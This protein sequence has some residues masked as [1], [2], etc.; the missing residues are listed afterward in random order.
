MPV[1]LPFHIDILE[2]DSRSIDF[3]FDPNALVDDA[4]VSLAVA[5]RVDKA[6]GGRQDIIQQACLAQIEA[7][8]EVKSE[9]IVLQRVSRVLQQL[10]LG[11]YLKATS[12]IIDLFHGQPCLLEQRRQRQ[13][14]IA[15]PCTNR[16]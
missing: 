13:S 16:P 2:R 6:A 5:H 14:G 15:Y 3:K 8:R 4:C 11:R 7:L 9:K 10:D 1:G 12:W